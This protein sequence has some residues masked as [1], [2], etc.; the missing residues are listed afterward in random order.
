MVYL[1]N[2]MILNCYIRLLVSEITIISFDFSELIIISLLAVHSTTMSID[3]WINDI[4]FVLHISN[5]V[6]SSTYL[7]NATG[8]IYM[9]IRKHLGPD[10]VPCG[11]PPLCRPVCE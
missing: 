4:P 5:T 6:L 3:S 9:Y 8:V 1:F 11:P 10:I 7:Y 2:Y